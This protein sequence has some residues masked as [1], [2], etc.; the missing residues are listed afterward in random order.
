L[1][2]VFAAAAVAATLL[3]RPVTAQDQLTIHVA[4]SAFEAQAD[5]YYAQ[6][7]GLFAKA[8]LNVDIQQFQ[9]GEAIVAGIVSGALQIG[10]GNP[11]P[12]A[13]AFERKFDV[14]L[15][16]PGTLTDAA[17]RPYNSGIVVAAN[18]PIRTGAD[19]NG[20]IVAV[21]T[22]HSI[23]QIAMQMWVDKNG[24]DS[25]TIKF[26]E[27][28]GTTIIDALAAGRFDAALLADPFY[29]VG[30]D[31]G[32]IRMIAFGNAAIAKRFMVT[33]W[34]ATRAWAN[35]NPDTVSKFGAALSQA[36]AW[37]VK[38]PEAAAAVLRKYLRTTTLL[39]HERHARTLDPGLIQPL[40]DAA[41]QYKV[42]AKP[43][44]AR[45]IILKAPF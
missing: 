36:S 29:T 2:R 32:R 8:G 6:D 7:L 13:N 10:A 5:A 12:L 28:P 14:V 31:S 34:F 17:L 4:V 44:D 38:N 15:V 27:A 43:L 41:V 9:G 1:R 35:K 21:N 37:A 11:L 39:A 23:D 25:K 18:S 45:E 26:V 22:L 24:G 19:L 33:A 40:I 20:K 16:A 42:L 30:I 3:I